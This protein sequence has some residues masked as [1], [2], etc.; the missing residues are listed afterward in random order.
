[1]KKINLLALT[2]VAIFFFAFSSNA[3]SY[4]VDNKASELLWTGYKVTGQHNGDI[5]ISSGNLSV[6]DSKISGSFTIDMTT[7]NTLDLEGEYKDNLDGHLA[8]A[9]FFDVEN[10]AS[11]D[12]TITKISP[13]RPVEGDNAT[14]KVTGDLTIKGITNEIEFPAMIK[15]DDE[16]FTAEAAFAIDRTKWNVEYGASGGVFA[17]FGDKM[18]YDDVEFVLNLVGKKVMKSNV[19]PASPTLTPTTQ[20]GDRK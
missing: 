15:V 1:M 4:K 6:V 8:S 3:Q 19:N 13:V 18:I 5:K 10:H 14:H 11:A 9:D 12:F 17:N 2:F 20:P 7:I 16:S